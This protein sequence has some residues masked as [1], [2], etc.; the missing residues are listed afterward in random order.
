MRHVKSVLPGMSS[1]SLPLPSW[2]PSSWR[3]SSWRWS[4]MLLVLAYGPAM[5]QSTDLAWRSIVTQ[6]QAS[7][8]RM[9][10]L[11]VPA[12]ATVMGRYRDKYAPIGGRLG[13]LFLYPRFGVATEA[14]DNLFASNSNRASDQTTRLSAQALLTS[15]WSRHAFDLQAYG[16]Q[17]LHASHASED[18]ANYGGVMDGRVDIG[19]SSALTMVASAEHGT[20]DRSDFTSPTNARKP[21]GYDRYYGE[22]KAQHTFNRLQVSG[23]VRLAR[24][25]YG[26]T[27]ARDGSL[28]NQTFR[29]G[30][31]LTYQASVSYRLHDGLR[32]IT[33][34]SYAVANYVAPLP[35]ALNRNSH[36]KRIEGGVRFDITDHVVGFVRAGWLGVDYTDSRLRS[37]DGAA[38][39]ADMI[40]TMRRSTTL[41]IKADRR[42]DENAST[43][44][45]GMRVTE[46]SLSLEHE[47]F[48]NLLLGARG[49]YSD[50]S[51][52]GP[53]AK[54]HMVSGGGQVRYLMSRRLNFTLDLLH[55]E[56]SSQSQAWQFNENRF[57]LQANVTL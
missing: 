42:V 38:F 52:L 37:F 15:N 53:D 22:A 43:T 19:A 57:T 56:R 44:S 21:V 7:E 18:V 33:N 54:S 55:Q 51:P 1:R 16:N 35:G 49:S 14:S 20:L 26:D 2:N 46:G 48:P 8:V 5:A 34:G 32:I 50:L 9:E 27:L 45:A 39:S 11:S 30:D 41:R 17:S 29:N 12:S 25:E 3:R 40:W 23:A 6:G 10:T 28:I 31:F 24:L 36:K 13:S 47:L 4:P